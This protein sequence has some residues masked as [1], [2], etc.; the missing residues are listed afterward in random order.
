MTD[1]W[2]II[3]QNRINDL[4]KS[5]QSL[6]LKDELL[7]LMREADTLANNQTLFLLKL[8]KALE[9]TRVRDAK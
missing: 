6:M 9:N 1:K 4:P 3:A 7:S 8:A 5:E 2:Y